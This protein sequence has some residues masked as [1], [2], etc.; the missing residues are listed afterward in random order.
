VDEVESRID[1]G[2][3]E[4]GAWLSEQLGPAALRDRMMSR[5]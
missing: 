1:E 4:A 5:P 3:E 2:A